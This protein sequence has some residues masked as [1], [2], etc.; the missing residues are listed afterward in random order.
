MRRAA[1]RD[2]NEG[3]IVSALEAVGCRVQR[4]NDHNAPDLLV[5][6]GGVN[7]L[8]EVKAPAGSRGGVSHRELSADQFAWH[9]KWLGPVVVVRTVDEALK[10]IGV[11][12]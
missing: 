11:R 10:A 4:L 3:L 8:L 5:S 7:Y 2:S 12:T 1:K 6:R 9:T